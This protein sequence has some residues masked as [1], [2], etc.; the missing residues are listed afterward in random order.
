MR[1]A[2]AV[3]AAFLLA[4][5]VGACGGGKDPSTTTGSSA[6]RSASRTRPVT[7]RQG[8]ESAADPDKDH[9][10][11]TPDEDDYGKPLK[12]DRDGDSDNTTNSY[13]DDDDK[14]ILNYGKTASTAN[15]QAIA[16]LV[17]R[18][19]SLATAENGAKA[20][21]LLYSTYAEAVPEDYGTSPP[22]PAYAKGKTCA[23]VL[24]HVFNHSHAQLQAKL[25][26]LRVTGIRVLGHLGLAVLSFHGIP[27]SEVRVVREGREWKLQTLLDNQ[28]P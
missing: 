20:C 6:A 23:V 24:T 19:Y 2:I 28:M 4:V 13:F 25:H 11:A 21:S 9:D 17:K 10:G 14:P 27:P 3:W 7:T 26:S 16:G 15:E 1:R 8:E 22:G 5:C 18:Y 12:I